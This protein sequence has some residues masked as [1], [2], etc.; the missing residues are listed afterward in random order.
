M[1]K[2]NGLHDYNSLD[3]WMV[4][5]YIIYQ[6]VGWSNRKLEKVAICEKEVVMRSHGHATL[7]GTHIGL[8]HAG[9]GASWYQQLKEWWA[10][11]TSA[12]RQAKLAALKA[13]WDAEHEAI[14]PLRADAAIEMAIAQ[15]TLSVAMQP[16]SLTQ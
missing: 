1:N 10:L 12:R 8:G 5:A 9:G 13:C 2:N 6:A 7:W 15:G 14:K 3:C 11:R 16:Y 4:A